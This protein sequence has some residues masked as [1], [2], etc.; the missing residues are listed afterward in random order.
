MQY[1]KRSASAYMHNTVQV[2]N[3]VHDY[4]CWRLRARALKAMRYV[5]NYCYMYVI[6]LTYKRQM[7]SPAVELVCLL[8]HIESSVFVELL[9]MVLL[10]YLQTESAYQF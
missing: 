3:H 9:L 6:R 7:I 4:S 10:K 5:A 8:S 2:T 1:L